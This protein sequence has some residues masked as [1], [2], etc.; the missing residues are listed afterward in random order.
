MS[1]SAATAVLSSGGVVTFPSPLFDT[2]LLTIY[3]PLDLWGF[4]S[5]YVVAEYLY[6][7]FAAATLSHA[8]KNSSTSSSLG[9]WFGC[10]L[11]GSIV[12]LFTILSPEIGNFYHTQASVMLIGKTEPL[13]MLVGCYGGIQYLAVQLAFTA[14]G[15][16][17][18]KA[19]RK[20]GVT[21]ISGLAGRYLWSLLDIIGAHFLWW[22]W[23]ESD[24][25]YLAK[26]SGVSAYTANLLSTTYLLAFLAYCN[27]VPIASSFW[28]LAETASIGF[29]YSI[30]RRRNALLVSVTIAVITPLLLNIPFILLYHP[31]SNNYGH[32]EIPLYLLEAAAVIAVLLMVRGGHSVS[33]HRWL[34]YLAGSFVAINSAIFIA[35]QDRAGR[36][37]RYSYGEPF[38]NSSC[39][40]VTELVFWGTAERDRFLCPAKIGSD[41]LYTLSCLKG[42]L[43][44]GRWYWLC[45]VGVSQEAFVEVCIEVLKTSAL[46][47]FLFAA[48]LGGKRKII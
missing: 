17:D 4:N 7:L 33:S 1:L 29:I 47:F 45:G 27:Q 41:K 11:S 36:N 3:N 15:D 10:L 30:V 46:I 24:K 14:A 23:H 40:G 39:H 2:E 26:A 20:L 22:V 16:T 25:L 6:L 38:T 42:P 5:S 31:F 19:G 37:L 21:L 32:P 8:W 9:L 44:E 12:E 48:S 13:Y 35:F 34:F 18:T 43:M 28:I